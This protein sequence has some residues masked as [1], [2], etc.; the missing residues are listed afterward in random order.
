M[1]LE[2]LVFHELLVH[3]QVRGK[4]RPIHYYRTGNGT[5]IDFLIETQAR[6]L[7]SPPRVVCVEVNRPINEPKMG[8]R[9]SRTWHTDGGDRGAH[10]RGIPGLAPGPFDGFDV[11]PWRLFSPNCTKDAYSDGGR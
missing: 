3:S 2:N 4:D 6:W 9:R 8:A 7:G 5:E 1:A 10:D 11:L